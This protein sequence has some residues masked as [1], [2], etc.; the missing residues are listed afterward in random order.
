MRWI[1]CF[2]IALCAQVGAVSAQVGPLGVG[3]TFGAHGPPPAPPGPL[4]SV[5][6]AGGSASTASGSAATTAP[7]LADVP[8]GSLIV[9]AVDTGY[10]DQTFS[11]CTD[12]ATGGSNAYSR[13]QASANASVAN[14]AIVYS[15]SVNDLPLGSEWTCTTSGGGTWA[16]R[17]AWYASGYE[18]GLDVSATLNQP[19]A[20]TSVAGVSTGTLSN[21]GDLVVGYVYPNAGTVTAFTESPGFT[22]LF[23]NGFNSI[24]YA[25]PGVVTS[26]AYAP[27]WT[28]G[29]SIYSAALAAFL[30]S[31][32][33]STTFLAR[34]SGL[35][36]T[37]ISAYTNL[38]CG[39]VSDGTWSLMN[40]L[41]VFATNTTTTAFLNLKSTSFGLTQVSTCTFTADSNISC[42]GT[43]GYLTTGYVPSAVE[44]LNNTAMG[45]CDLTNTTP[46]GFTYPIGSN[47]NTSNADWTAIGVGNSQMNFGLSGGVQSVSAS[48]TQGSWIVSRTTSTLTTFY[49][50]GASVATASTASAALSG[51]QNYIG[52][53]NKVGSPLGYNSNEYGYAFFSNSLTSTQALAVYNR[54]H[55][56]LSAVGAPSGC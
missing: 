5:M 38:I 53:L 16:V 9:I 49:L 44:T 11:S 46:V 23:N 56:F 2:L 55:A 4:T 41:Y 15:I 25:L 48:S 14:N 28:G 31:C 3:P 39:M 22:N 43:S 40:A 10:T 33:Q 47:D 37:E 36:V 32:S 29:S 24:D 17:G 26:L 45:I 20:G 27:S 30:P 8:A 18:G 42:N 35:S 52:A 34:T 21:A 19:T 54:F 13:V 51:V 6:T 1:A 7:S 50:N 12:N